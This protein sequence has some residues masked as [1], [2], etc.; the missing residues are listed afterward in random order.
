[1]RRPVKYMTKAR[2]IEC[3][4]KAEEWGYDSKLTLSDVGGV[5]DLDYPV[6]LALAHLNSW[7]SASRFVQCVVQVPYRDDKSSG[8]LLELG[9]R[10]GVILLAE[11]VEDCLHLVV[12]VPSAWYD[13]LPTLQADV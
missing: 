12:D 6:L 2:L 3:A 1:M 10:V 5:P 8:G 13:A 7:G 4:Q 9:S 11:T